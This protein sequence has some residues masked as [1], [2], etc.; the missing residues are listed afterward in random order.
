MAIA[1]EKQDLLDA[2]L[3]TDLQREVLETFHELLDAF[4][5]NNI[6]AT[7]E[8]LT[9]FADRTEL[10]ALTMASAGLPGLMD[11]CQLVQ[12]SLRPLINEEREI[13]QQ[14]Q[15]LIADWP[16]LLTSYL[17]DPT[18]SEYADAIISYLMRLPWG[19]EQDAGAFSTDEAENLR[20][21]LTASISLNNINLD[22]D[23]AKSDKQQNRNQTRDLK[24]VDSNEENRDGDTTPAS[25]Q[26]QK[27][28]EEENA[29]LNSEIL[30]GDIRDNL[31]DNGYESIETTDEGTLEDTLTI[32]PDEYRELVTLVGMEIEASVVA[33]SEA[34][35]TAANEHESRDNRQEALRSYRGQVGR[36]SA[37]AESVGLIGLQKAL[38]YVIKLIKEQHNL[39]EILSATQEH[40]FMQWPSL[41]QIYLNNL[42]SSKVGEPLV[43]HLQTAPWETDLIN[44][45]ESHLVELLAAPT[46]ITDEEEA[47]PRQTEASID[48]VSLRLPEDVN[49]QLIDSLLQELPTQTAELTTFITRIA[50]GTADLKDVAV[51]NRIAHT[52]KGSANTVGV[53]GVATLTHHIEDIL[54]TFTKH[55]CMPGHKLAETLLN[56]ADVLEMMSESM[57]GMGPEPEQARDVLQAVLDW[58]NHID[59]EGLPSDDELSDQLISTSESDKASKSD[60][61]TQTAQIKTEQNVETEEQP[62]KTEQ[63]PDLSTTPMLRIPASV[64]DE[65]LRLV[66]ETTILN[67][68]LQ[69][70]LRQAKIYTEDVHEQN[71]LFQQ[72]TY[73][74]EQLVDVQGLT[75]TQFRSGVTEPLIG[76]QG[77]QFDTLE[78]DQYNELHT[79]THRLVEAATDS[80]EMTQGIEDQ[81]I[82]LD[83]LLVDQ[84][85][86]HRENQEVVMRTRMIPVQN[87]V[88]RLQR[89][90]R[91]TCRQTDKLAEL[92]ITGSDT[93][94]DSDVLNELA[95]P[96]MHILRNAIDHGIEPSNS[97]EANGKSSTGHLDLSFTRE[98]E[99]IV[100]RC[101]DDGAGLDTEAILSAAIE[102]GLVEQDQVCTPE[103]IS[104]LIL[105][106][107]FTTRKVTT[108]V[109][110]RGIGMDVV[111]S[112]IMG[113]K[114]SLDIIS[115]PGEGCTVELRI[116][117]TL[118]SIHALLV[119][120]KN[121][122]LAISSRGVEQ[123]VY[124]GAGTI[125]DE[126]KQYH[127]GDQVYEACDLE[128][129]LGI[130]VGNSRTDHQEKAILLVRSEASKLQA[131][132]VEEIRATQDLVLKQMG[133]Y[134]PAT[135]GIAGA[136]ILGDGSVAP[137]LD[138]PEL[139]RTSTQEQI[140][141][142]SDGL[143]SHEPASNLPIA[144]VVDDSLSARR[145][146]AE[147]MADSGYEVIAARDGLDAIELIQQRRPD[148]LLVDLEMP[149]MNGL[150]LTS[151]VRANQETKHIPVI[152]ITSRSTEKHR[153]QAHAT[154][155]NI[156]LT[157]PFTEDV[158][159]E[160]VEDEL[161]RVIKESEENGNK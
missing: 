119:Q 144:M 74:L 61:I 58:A 108:Q 75:S 150:E 102:A 21:L 155:V 127:L 110:G 139:L 72:L 67:G 159:M 3:R 78:F 143:T 59:Q 128:S 29:L 99:H 31:I 46:I 76:S 22:D 117:L 121:Q 63:L 90:V 81:L 9:L 105:M 38:D 88:P 134:V 148:I 47:E 24:I 111:Y 137:V 109:S 56:A 107:G 13:S 140:S 80:R 101:N 12:H 142:F 123:I 154:G 71:L 35:H 141:V 19:N 133:Q 49:P 33:I 45:S 158:L 79:V 160:H 20:D 1:L 145:A 157:K 14:E 41:L 138:L 52:L 55:K 125:E 91:Q 65:L 97:R 27:N 86:L 100:V 62:T 11:A 151:H 10:L 44:V 92:V 87:I 39:G 60:E 116:P 122:V 7:H 156:Y 146:L 85:R 96:L 5:D 48:D 37:A 16:C 50:E 114:G 149:R 104:R 8:A 115:S 18:K 94:I 147:F 66:G 112:R 131:V 32:I 54:E 84:G 124:P 89:S 26:V 25:D 6:N 136:T 15:V 93:L 4:E 135:M 129:L 40:W 64:V 30:D 82:A 95:D 98:G 36:F 103:E 77:E 42:G 83:S 57:L 106:P 161:K 126:G 17:A 73:E 23:E 68:Q 113:M 34:I 70:R 53:V 118:I 130:S 43:N 2:G 69:E 153:Q 28:I 152:M 51:A 132:S 120:S